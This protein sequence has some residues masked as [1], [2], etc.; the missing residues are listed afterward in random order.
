MLPPV[1]CL[2][3]Q[4]NCLQ[5]HPSSLQAFWILAFVADVPRAPPPPLRDSTPL[6]SLKKLQKTEVIAPV[7]LDIW[8]R[9]EQP[10]ILYLHSVEVFFW[11]GIGRIPWG[12]V[13]GASRRCAC[14]SAGMTPCKVSGVIMTDP[15]L[16]EPDKSRCQA[17]EKGGSEASLTDPSV[18]NEVQEQHRGNQG[19]LI[20]FSL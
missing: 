4:G 14:L 10:R 8:R 17:E 6:I 19:I 7:P 20:K 16:M 5:R 9:K 18:A 3:I 11:Q 13:S 12:R 15:C 2:P 1:T